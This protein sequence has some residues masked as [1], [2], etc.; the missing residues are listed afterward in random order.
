MKV[1][2]RNINEKDFPET[3]YRSTSDNITYKMRILN[4]YGNIYFKNVCLIA[5]EETCG[6]V[7]VLNTRSFTTRWAEEI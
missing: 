4:N 3:K 2:L 6:R 7:T 5:V 1:H